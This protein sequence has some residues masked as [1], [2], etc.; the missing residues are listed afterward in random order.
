MPILEATTVRR[1]ICT[2][3]LLSGHSL[4]V[5]GGRVLSTGKIHHKNQLLLGEAGI[6]ANWLF[7]CM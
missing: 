6:G 3:W 5:I 1:M 2:D 7:S 4:S